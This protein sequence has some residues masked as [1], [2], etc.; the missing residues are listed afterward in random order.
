MNILISCGE[1]SGDLYAGALTRELRSIDDSVRVSGLGSDRLKDAGA[2]LV[3]DFRGLTVTG[4]S[5]ALK[6]IPRSVATLRRLILHARND[7]P[8]VF[9]PIDF[10]DFNFRVHT[11]NL[12]CPFIIFL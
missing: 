8:D 11:L 4:L 2:E 6:V 12:M 1:P 10:P 7:P 3:E 9:V 5:E